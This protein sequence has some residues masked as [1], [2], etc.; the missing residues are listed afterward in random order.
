MSKLFRKFKDMS[1]KNRIMLIMAFLMTM[2]AIVAIPT[3]AWFNHQ[4]QIAEM[5]KVKTPDL[6]YISAAYAED[7]K[8][9]EIPAIDVEDE[10]NTKNRKIF[11]FAV[12][13]E[14]VTTFTLQLAHTT[15][16]PF[17][18]K[19][20]EAEAYTSEAEARSAI[21]EK[22]ESLSEENKLTFEDDAVE[23]EVKA[24]WT[25]LDQY[26]LT[27]RTVNAGQKIFFVKGD[28]VNGSYLNETTDNGR[29]IATDKYQPE[30]YETENG[31]YS[32]VQKYAKPLYWQCSGI[33]SVDQSGWGTKPF[34]KSFIL[35]ISWNDGITNDKETDMVYISAYRDN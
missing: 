30:T 18:Y 5:Q 21:N 27:Q 17:T 16:I 2:A 9:F 24:K 22:N 13:G 23:Y 28:Q 11:P 25:M 29:K 6:L 8:Y 15:N 34:F 1:V 20:Y 33:Q 32:N 14:Y 4:R 19:I 3:V 26:D 10:N 12:A 7:V 31:T 35:E